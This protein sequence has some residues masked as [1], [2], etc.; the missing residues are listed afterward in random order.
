MSETHYAPTKQ[1]QPITVHQPRQRFTA[2][3]LPCSIDEDSADIHWLVFDPHDSTLCVSTTS[4]Y[5]TVSTLEFGINDDS[6]AGDE[7][8]VI[9]DAIRFSTDYEGDYVCATV[10]ST[11]RCS[12][13]LGA[14]VVPLRGSHVLLRRA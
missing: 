13:R 1:A 7:I 2:A 11:V 9:I 10:A 12:Q 8:E 5:V 3:G 4:E 14:V 6:K